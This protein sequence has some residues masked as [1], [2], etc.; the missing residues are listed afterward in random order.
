MKRSLRKKN[1]SRSC[2][3]PNFFAM[4]TTMVAALVLYVNFDPSPAGHAAEAEMMS[5]P[6]LATATIIPQPSPIPSSADIDATLSKASGDQSEGA[7]SANQQYLAAQSRLALMISML[8]LEKGCQK[9]EHIPD[10]T[11][12]FFK[13]ERIDGSLGDG[14]LMN[15]KI[16][17]EPYSIYM[18]WLNGDKGRELLYVDGHN[19]GK[20]IVHAGG[21]KAR[22]LPALKLDPTGS[23]AMSESRHPVMK[24]GLLEF[25]RTI[26]N[27]RR[28]DLSI[29]KQVRCCMLENA[30]FEGRPCYCFIAEYGDQQE[31]EEYRKSVCYIDKELSLPICVKN[32]GWP[33]EDS[34]LAG[35]ELDEATM[36]EFYTYTDIKIDQ[37][38]ADADFDQTN[39]AYK[40]RR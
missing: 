3:G 27:Y 40:F 29:R 16:R 22:L 9:L 20:M 33:E 35:E 13:Q 37:Q 34:E 26:L 10:Y 7:N 1:T 23:L 12:K 8:M 18:L 30:E 4:V 14:Q 28:D 24:A 31:S 32:F 17:H 2:H 25:T 15:L 19:E 11:A 21:W 38:L 36:T 6:R 39:S 5:T